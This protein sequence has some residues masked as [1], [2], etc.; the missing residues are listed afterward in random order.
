MIKE[1]KR[2][3]RANKAMVESKLGMTLDSD[4]PALAFL[5]S[6]C[7][8]QMSRHRVGKDGRTPLQKLTGRQWQR[9]SVRFA[10]KILIKTLGSA[11]RKNDF[12]QRMIPGHYVGHHNRHGSVLVLTETGLQ[13]GS[14]FRR[15][16]PEEQWDKDLKEA[17]RKRIEQI[18]KQN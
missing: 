7:A 3:I 14:G 16:P 18:S 12:S 17:A 4:D 15:L 9:H 1:L 13:I 6:Y 10:E 5:P 2:R 8:D 11:G